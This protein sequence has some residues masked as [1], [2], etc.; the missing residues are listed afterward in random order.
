[1]P[2]HSWL[3]RTGSSEKQLAE[4][5]GVCSVMGEDFYTA[6]PMHT[7][8]EGNLTKALVNMKEMRDEHVSNSN[9]N[10]KS[11]SVWGWIQSLIWKKALQAVGMVIGLLPL[12]FMV[13]SCCVSPILRVTITRA[14]KL[15]SGKFP[16][17]VDLKVDM[18]VM[19]D[20]TQDDLTHELPDPCWMT[21]HVQRAGRRVLEHLCFCPLNPKY[22]FVKLFLW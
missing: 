3:C 14:I 7:G 5:Q 8:T 11:P 9:W 2:P 13:V 20:Q 12:T 21:R 4:E 15:V 16:L 6:I 19:L 1:M 17:A 22:P 10:T 18:E